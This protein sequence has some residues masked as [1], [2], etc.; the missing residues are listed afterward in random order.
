MGR[1]TIC[2]SPKKTSYERGCR[3]E[4]I[5]I[6]W[7]SESF[8]KAYFLQTKVFKM[9]KARFAADPPILTWRNTSI[10]RRKSICVEAEASC[11]LFLCDNWV[12]FERTT[13]WKLGDSRW[14]QALF[15]PNKPIQVRGGNA[16][17]SPK[18]TIHGRKE[19]SSTLYS[20]ENWAGCERNSSCKPLFWSWKS[21]HFAANRPIQ[22]SW[23]NPCI[24]QMKNTCVSSRSI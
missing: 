5:V 6:P 7:D 11:T 1:R 2:I 21:T 12:N 22:L 20:S 19:A 13:S 9:E 3:I 23:W 10:S 16:C 15:A 24:P 4:H 18:T 14:R 17:N 8:W